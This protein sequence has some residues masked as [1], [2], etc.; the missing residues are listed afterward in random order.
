[1]LTWFEGAHPSLGAGVWIAPTAVVVGDVQ[2][3]DRTSIWFQAV[4]RGDEAPV[5][6]G[7][8]TNVQD[9]SILHVASERGLVIGNRVSV[10]HAAILHACEV[11][12]GALIGMGSIVMDGAVIGRNCIVAAGSLVPA[13]A[14]FQGDGQ[15]LLGRP[16]KVVRA[17]TPEEIAKNE[18]RAQ[19][20]V[21]NA[22]KYAQA[23][24]GQHE[25]SR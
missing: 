12:D 4:V 1:M 6:I 2:I 24:E 13:G 11:R 10:G 14:Q 7:Q 18:Q 17:V 8:E 23:H 5:R 16:A 19:K 25:S 21:R 9:G 15:V 22:L 20:Y 3:G